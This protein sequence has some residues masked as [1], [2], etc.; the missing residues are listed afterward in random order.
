L[1]AS[2]VVITLAGGV[3]VAAAASAG[4]FRGSRGRPPGQANSGPIE[5]QSL[6][7]VG[8]NLEH[9]RQGAANTHYPRVARAH[10]ADGR[11]QPVAG[12]N[13]RYISN[14]VFNDAH[15]NV[16][17]ETEVTQWGWVWGQFL[18]HT[19][20]LRQDSP[21]GDASAKRNIAFNANDPLESFTNTLGVI[22]FTRSAAAPRTG[23]SNPREQVNTV[24][25][26]IDAFAVYGDES[27]LEWLR[28]GPVDGNLRNNSAMLLLQD[29]YLPTADARGNASTAPRMEVDGRLRAR[30]NSAVIA[31]DVRA[32]ENIALSAI[33]N[34]FAR[35]H[36]RI[37]SQLPNRLP[38][39]LKFQI[40]R[41]IV[42]AEQQYITYQEFL[43][44][45]GVE[46]DR[47]RGYSPRVDTSITNEFATVGYRAHSQIHGEF[48]FEA[49][50]ADYTAAERAALTAQGIEILQ[51]EGSDE[52]EIV[53]PLNVAFF[54]PTLVKQIGLD[55]VLHGLG[56]EAQYNNEEMIDNQLRS[57]MFQIPASGN[58]QCL[59][60]AELPACFRGVV[61]LGAIDV[62]R[63]RDHGMPSYNEMRRAYGLR[64]VTSFRQ[65][66]GEASDAFPAD[67]LLT[68]GKEIDDPQSLDYLW[69]KNGAG[70]VVD[71]D[72]EE[73]EGTVV[74]TARR[75]PLAARLK[76]IYGTVDRVDAFVG[77]VAE[78]HRTNAEMGELQTVMWKKQFQALRD[79]DRFFYGND[80]GLTHI[81]RTFNID[82]RRTLAQVIAANTDIPLS[83]LNANVF[84]VAPE[85]PTA[86]GPNTQPANPVP[87]A[88]APKSGQP[89]TTSRRRR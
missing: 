15:Q 71:P 61:D 32:N 80:P 16:F 38:E 31:G 49:E 3:A 19:F 83:E 88:P 85:A 39:E 30:P 29:G 72:S 4:T 17:S 22:P 63:G 74:S 58:P 64:P 70:E 57:V 68:P 50:A 41:R 18:D 43:P 20:G 86:T 79:G 52:I 26:Y 11:S 25:S 59:D 73:A 2:L 54:N 42:I 77:M 51:D 84:E 89:A 75:A 87:A 82:Y 10:Y 27:R 56:L 21:A 28:A 78:R 12:P 47:Y 33:Q 66:T 34:L 13:V 76:A 14:R 60:G 48:E 65:I 9:P 6:D 46:L 81:R 53:V 23:V 45:F 40:A 1:F 69:L 62:E 7:G 55:E 44:A 35:E 67:P 5:I 36:N 24:S 8:N 37:V